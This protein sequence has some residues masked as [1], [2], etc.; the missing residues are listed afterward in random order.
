[1]LSLKTNL[2]C[3]ISNRANWKQWLRSQ[4][5]DLH[6]K[7]AEVQR[8]SSCK[9]NTATMKD[10]RTELYKRNLGNK[11]E[12]FIR[13]NYPSIIELSPTQSPKPAQ[14]TQ[15][16]PQQQRPIAAATVNKH[17][18]FKNY[19]PGMLTFPHKK[20]FINPNKAHLEA[21]VQAFI[22]DKLGVDYI[23]IED[24]AYVEYFNPAHAEFVNKV[25]TESRDIYQYRAKHGS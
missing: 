16:Q 22:K 2:F 25:R 23:I 1:M 11:F 17:N 13:M 15:Q 9:Q 4:A 18:V 21:I 10:I 8:Q 24:H 19:K 3:G 5:P 12:E 7:L 6:D 20:I 14:S